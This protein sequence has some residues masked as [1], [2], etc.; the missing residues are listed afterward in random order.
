[1][2]G[3]KKKSCHAWEQIVVLLAIHF[4]VPDRSGG[5]MK[6]VRSS[7]F[8]IQQQLR[9]STDCCVQEPNAADVAERKTQLAYSKITCWCTRSR[10]PYPI[11]LVVS[12]L[13]LFLVERYL[14]YTRLKLQQSKQ[15]FNSAAVSNIRRPLHFV[16]VAISEDDTFYTAAYCFPVANMPCA[17]QAIMSF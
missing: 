16:Q 10:W 17:E 14:T 4:F 15:P 13:E 12:A 9:W 5:G 11:N 7:H 1:M 2:A 3:K 8:D 6:C